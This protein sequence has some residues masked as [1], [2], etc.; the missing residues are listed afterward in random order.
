MDLVLLLL[1]FD[2][3]AEWNIRARSNEYSFRAYRLKP[4]FQCVWAV[5]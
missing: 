3:G 4:E 5:R 2:C 1:L